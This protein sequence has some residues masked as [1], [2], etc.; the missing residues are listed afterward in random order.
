MAGTWT[1]EQAGDK[2]VEHTVFVQIVLEA[3]GDKATRSGRGRGQ[4]HSEFV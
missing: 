4:G 1:I 2:G 3:V